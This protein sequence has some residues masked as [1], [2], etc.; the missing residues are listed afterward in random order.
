MGK[1][2]RGRCG[3]CCTL[4]VRLNPEDIG[5]IKNLGSKE[6][7]FVEYTG[8]NEPI[9]RRI[10]GYCSFLKLEKGIAS[11]TIYG[12]RPKICREYT[13]ISPGE[14][15]CRLQR[16]YSVVELGKTG[17]ARDVEDN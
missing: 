5:R 8:R 9:L 12:S 1:L 14:P 15:E 16:H 10:N 3:L 13:C 17:G 6:E 7:G 11:C 4:L 2:E